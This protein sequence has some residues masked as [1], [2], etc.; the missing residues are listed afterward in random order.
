MQ[1]TPRRGSRDGF[2]AAFRDRPR[3]RGPGRNLVRFLAGG[4]DSPTVRE[5]LHAIEADIQ[6]FRL[7]LAEWSRTAAVALPRVHR[8]WVRARPAQLQDLLA[9]DRARAKIE[10]MKHLDGELT[11]S[12]RRRWPATG[13]PR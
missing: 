4:G 8:A 2:V 5:E 9:Q 3:A 12:P 1:G 11:I 13:G 6:A 10:I 7:E